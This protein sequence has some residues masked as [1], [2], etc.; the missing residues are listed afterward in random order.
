M[1]QHEDEKLSLSEKDEK[2]SLAGNEEKYTMQGKDEKFT[3]QGKD[4][5]YPMPGKVVERGNSLAS[6]TEQAV[7][8]SGDPYCQALHLPH[9][10][11]EEI[12]DKKYFAR[13]EVIQAAI[14]S[15]KT[16][17]DVLN[18]VVDLILETGNFVTT[19]DNFVFDICNL[20]PGTVVKIEI[21]MGVM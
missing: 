19:N 14:H 7:E 21:A 1:G 2:Y 20:D 16:S 4:E 18:A 8:G 12:Q 9:P 6:D 5:K 13:L 10:G 3:M 11:L 17:T 15:P